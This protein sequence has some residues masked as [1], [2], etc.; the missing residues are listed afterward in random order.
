MLR[1]KLPEQREMDDVEEEKLQEMSP[2]RSGQASRGGIQGKSRRRATR[3]AGTQHK[4]EAP[5]LG[6]WAI[7]LAHY[8]GHS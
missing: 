6:S 1:G 3:G 4:G 8:L 2:S 7:P 5:R